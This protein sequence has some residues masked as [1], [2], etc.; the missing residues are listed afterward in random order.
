M[1][2][3]FA[4][5]SRQLKPSRPGMGPLVAIGGIDVPADGVRDLETAIDAL[6]GEFG[7]PPGEAFKWSPGRE[8]WM[9]ENLVEADREEFF[10]RLLALARDGDVRTIVVMED[11][12]R[13][14]AT[15][16]ESREADVAVLFIERV[17]NQLARAGAE[18]IVIAAQPG[19]GRRDEHKFLTAC[20][21][22]LRSGTDYVQPERIAVNVL[23]SPSKFI[24]LLQLADVVTSCT[25]ATVGGE[26]R[27]SPPV[28]E[29]I[30]PLLHSDRG[31]IGGVGLKIHP[32]GRYANLYHWVVGDS[33]F[34]RSSVGIRLPRKTSAYS[35]GPDCP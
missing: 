17:H 35:E 26:D 9:H 8:L 20:L 11:T 7:F 4:D 5:D 19:G 14:A 13:R 10:K 18:G 1:R 2:F 16:A 27:F 33:H 22:T 30:K 31:R 25:V 29:M 15:S 23:S 3:F 6:C 21:E 24:R 12:S 32:D 34:V 28:F